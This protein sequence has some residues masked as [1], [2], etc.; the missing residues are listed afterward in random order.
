[1]RGL[2]VATVL[3]ALVVLAPGA[4]P[5]GP[6]PASAAPPKRDCGPRSARTIK[7]NRLV[8]VYRTEHGNYRACARHGGKSTG[9]D[10]PDKLVLRGR[11]L[12]FSTQ[13]CDRTGCW[14]F[15]DVLD[16]PRGEFPAGIGETP[17]S[18]TKFVATSHGEAALLATAPDGGRFVER[19]DFMGTKELDR[20]PD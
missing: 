19:A 7:R 20:G 8:R 3:S 2:I 12:T 6:A 14:F 16:V 18:V 10:R 9:I 5:P 13:F 15:L 17:G 1:M 4:P 11:Y